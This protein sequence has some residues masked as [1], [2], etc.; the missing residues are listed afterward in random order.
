MI[1]DDKIHIY[2][3]D[4]MLEPGEDG[5]SPSDTPPRAIWY[6]NL[7]EGETRKLAVRV[8]L[9]SNLMVGRRR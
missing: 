9:R 7:L 8:A 3:D 6:I 5:N 2:R 1:E 4:K